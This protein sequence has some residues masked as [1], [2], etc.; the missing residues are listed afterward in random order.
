LLNQ[1]T[2]SSD[3]GGVGEAGP[4]AHVGEVG[5]PEAVRLRRVEV[6]LHHVGR[7]RLRF[8]RYG[9][10]NPATPAD[11]FEAQ[12]AHQPRDRAA[13]DF[14]ALALEL[15]PELAHAVDAKV[16]GVDAPEQG[17]QSLVPKPVR[18]G[19]SPAGGIVGG[20]GDL[21]RLADRLDP[22]TGAERVDVAGHLGGRGSS[23]RAKKAAAVLRISFARLSS[24]F[25]RSSSCRCLRSSL[26][27]ALAEPH[28]RRIL[29]LLRV[30]ER[31][32]G[33]LVDELALSQPAVSKHLRVLRD[34]GLVDVR[35]DVQRRLYRVRPEPLRE[36]ELWLEPYRRMWAES[37]DDLQR[38]LSTMEEERKDER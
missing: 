13:G 1:S 4:G 36:I 37:P 12:V 31:P 8:A 27:E 22:K 21:Q 38:Y 28:R 34:A 24:R 6:A 18:R 2:H 9:R 11:A 19:R 7:S 25:S 10:A 3:E 15:M 20:R 14:G 5:H 16:L 33:E 17:L 29:D 32:V 26:F 23:S 30:R 35:A